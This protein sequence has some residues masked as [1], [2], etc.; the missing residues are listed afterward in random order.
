MQFYPDGGLGNLLFQHHAAYARARDRNLQLFTLSTYDTAPDRPCI[1]HYRQLFRHVNFVDSLPPPDY[2]ED[3]RDLSYRF[4][5]VEATC[6]KGYFQ[7]WKYFKKYQKELRTLLRANEEDKWA[8]AQRKYKAIKDHRRT[9]CLHIRLGDMINNPFHCLT[10]E[11]YYENAMKRFPGQRF[12]AFSDS[13]DI[14]SSFKFM[15]EYDVVLVNEGDPV[16]AFFMMSLCDDFIIPNSTLSL[17]AW[18]MRENTV[19]AA[20]HYTSE[21]HKNG[22]YLTN[23][24]DMV[25][26]KPTMRDVL[27]DQGV[28][29]NNGKIVIP[30]WVNSVKIDV[31]L[32]Y[33]AP[34]TRNWLTQNENCMVFG[35]EANRRATDYMFATPE[36]RQKININD[37]F[38]PTPDY[39][40]CLDYS[41]IGKRCYI[42]PV[43]LDLVNEPEMKTFYIVPKTDKSGEDCCSLMKPV[44]DF[45][46][47]PEVSQVMAYS[48]ADFMKLLPDGTVVDYIKTDVQGKDLDV[49][50]SAGDYI[51]QVIYITTEENTNQYENSSHNTLHVVHNYVKKKG[52]FHVRHPNTS[53]YT[54]LNTKYRYKYDV[55]IWQRG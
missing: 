9:V 48:L 5:P 26:V 10:S 1:G 46:S 7:S 43:A 11:S 51:K 23:M 50:K 45:C 38:L 13:P 35:F 41:L 31:G 47:S 28:P 19:D 25:G 21:W 3:E 20:L 4:I 27:L 44:D 39:W 42:L 55:Y 17:M 2:T 54:F 22:A 12:I 34:H 36:E 53:D 52:F 24:E 49:I 8:I 40:T 6:I 15:K 30:A 33:D 37:Y 29:F 14:A 18:H 32:R 16:A